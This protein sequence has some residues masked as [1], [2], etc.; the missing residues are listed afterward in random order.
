MR[1]KSTSRDLP[2]NMLRRTRIRKSGL[3]WIRYYYNGRD[4]NGKRKEILLGSDLTEAKRKWAEL[5]CPPIPVD[6]SLCRYIFNRYER[7]IISQKAVGT[8]KENGWSLKQLRITFND[9][10]ISSITPHHIAHYRDARTAKVRANRELSLLS[11]IYNM[12]REW[13]FTEKENP[14]RGVRKNKEHPRDFY[15]DAPVWDAVYNAACEELRDAMDI[16]YL[17]GQRNADTLKMMHAHVKN[18]ALE[19]RQGKTK[20]ILRI[21]LDDQDIRSELGMTIDKILARKGKVKS[22]YLVANKAG[23]PLNKGTLRTRFDNARIA[24]IKQVIAEK[25]GDFQELAIRIKQFQFRDIRP[26]A[27]LEIADIGAASRLLGHTEQEITKKVYR[28]VGE[29]VKPTR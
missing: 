15:A 13:G 4:E 25:N 1:P 24:A 2:P 18:G 11:N 3:K 14:C 22:V 26:K 5:D 12:A 9:A 19:V 8:Q 20:K 29:N 7:D 27:A 23:Q 17:T 10:P 21:V 16:A 28:R 6:T